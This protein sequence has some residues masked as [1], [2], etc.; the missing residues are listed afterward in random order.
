V[1]LIPN[2]LSFTVWIAY[3]LSYNWSSSEYRVEFWSTVKQSTGLLTVTGYVCCPCTCWFRIAATS[4]MPSWKLPWLTFGVAAW[5][6]EPV[7]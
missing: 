5:Q 1:L 4:Y 2:L 3:S 7:D 6:V